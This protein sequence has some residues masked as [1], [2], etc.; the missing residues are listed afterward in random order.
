M[1]PF[2]LRPRNVLVFF[3]IFLGTVALV[4][5]AGTLVHR[6]ARL[7]Q[8]L[9]SLSSNL[10]A[11]VERQNQRGHLLENNQRVATTHLQEVRALMNLPTAEFRFSLDDTELDPGTE[12]DEDLLL[13]ALD[14]IAVH[15]EREALQKE[16]NELFSPGSSLAEDLRQ[17]NLTI[18]PGARRGLWTLE[19]PLTD[20]TDDTDDTDN[21]HQTDSLSP[22]ATISISG[23]TPPAQAVIET[24][25]GASRRISYTGTLRERHQQIS[26]ALEELLP[27]AREHQAALAAKETG[28]TGQDTAPDE[29]PARADLAPDEAAREYLQTRA[30]TPR[31]Q[32]R[33]AEHRLHLAREPRETLDFYVFDIT[34][35]EGDTPEGSSLG[36]LA[37]LKHTGEIYLLDQEDIMITGLKTLGKEIEAL[38]NPQVS[39]PEDAQTLPESFPP[40]FRGGSHRDGTNILL[41]G[42]H[43]TKA[44]SIMLLHLSPEKTISIVSIPRDLYYQGRKLS[45]HYEIY[46]ARTFL[47]RISEIIGREIDAYVSIDM[48][49]FIE[50]VDILGGIT[51]TLEEPLRDPTYRVRDNGTWSTLSFPAG[52]HT[53]SGVEALRIARSRATTT[54]FGRSSRQHDI[55]EALRRR[56]NTLHAGNL[57]QVYRLIQTLAT[58][59]ETDLTPWE[60]TQF[61]LAYR[62]API[63]NRSGMTYYNILYSTYSNVHYQ[64]ITLA[65]AEARENFFMGLWILLP[66]GGNW[67]VIRWFVDENTGP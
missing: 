40:G 28:K 63:T 4:V 64:G 2:T 46:G 61:F 8:K 27:R 45:D 34:S 39:S 32:E 62:N 15:H 16:L 26:T 58:Y 7:Q 54:D 41:V 43:E 37:V 14:R 18:E 56:I 53:L 3:L 20:D 19:A 65:E 5:T 30:A 42:T 52:T 25:D 13:R 10:S 36:S 55:L 17:K 51:L 9:E 23:T 24:A 33:L 59:V 12:D 22:L 50:V 60:I 6:T 57:S 11:E 66:R 38:S 44:D 31:V 35:L 48:Y 47:A 21:T 1:K 67:D 49:A 29:A